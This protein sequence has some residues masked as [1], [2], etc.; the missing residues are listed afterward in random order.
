[1]FRHYSQHFDTVEINNSFYRLPE[2]ETFAAW[3]RAAP[4][5][6]LFA[7]KASRFLTH[8]KK[9]KDPEPALERLLEAAEGL[10]RK[11]GP[12]LLQLPPGWKLNLERLA[13][14]LEVL[15]PRHRFT[16]EFREPTWNDERVYSLLRRHNAAYCIYELA[17]FQTL[18]ITTA[19][20]AYVRLHGPGE[21][22]QGNYSRVQLAAWAKRIQA[23]SRE[24]RAVYVY[25]DNDQQACAAHNAQAL[26]K[27]LGEGHE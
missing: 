18:L 1:M 10:G 20:W 4:P 14:F 12:I 21:K 16:F 6:F 11:L 25:F 23:W 9:L 3:R 19:D 7:V 2:R 26:R 27:L 5:G 8:N 24:M 22:Y 17:G 13:E 15:P